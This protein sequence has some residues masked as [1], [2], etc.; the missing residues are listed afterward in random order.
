M[1]E[2]IR[3]GYYQSGQNDEALPFQY[4]ANTR[5]NKLQGNFNYKLMYYK[6]ALKDNVLFNHKNVVEC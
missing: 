1:K 4:P 2:P 3:L 6:K 5:N